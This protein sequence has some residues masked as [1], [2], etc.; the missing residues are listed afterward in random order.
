MPVPFFRGAA[1]TV[2]ER[3]TALSKGTVPFSSNENWDSPPLILSPVLSYVR[4]LLWGPGGD[5][6]THGPRES[7]S[8][9]DV[10]LKADPTFA[11][12]GT[13]MH[14][15][16]IATLTVGVFLLGWGIPAVAGDI[17]L[18][19]QICKEGRPS[20]EPITLVPAKTAVVVVD[21]WDRHW[22]KTYTL[23]VGNL[24]P[25]MNQ[26]LEAAR[27][28]GI[29]VVFAP[30][31]VVGFYKN[32]PQRKAMQAVP[33]QREPKKIAFNAPA[34]PQPIRLLRVRARPAV[35]ERKCLD[36]AA[37]GPEI[38]EGDL[39]GDCNNGRELLN[40]CAMRGID[41]LLYMGVASNMCVQYRSMGMRNMKQHGLRVLMTADLVE[42]ITSNGLDAARKKDLNFTPAGGTARVQQHVEQYLAPTFES[43]QLL[44]AAGMG[45]TPSTSGRTSFLI[46]AESEY[47]SHK[48]L[49]AFARKYLDKDYHCTC[50]AANGHEGSGRDDIPGLEAVDD[51]DLVVLSMRRRSLPVVQ[52]DHLERYLAPASRWWPCARASRRFKP[53]KIPSRATWCGS[54]STRRSWAAI[55]GLQPQVACHRLRRMGRR[56]GGQPPDPQRRGGEISQPL[57]AL[58]PASPGR[59]DHHAV[60]GSLVAGR[61]RR[62]RGLDEHLSGRAGVLHDPGPSGRFSDRVVQSAVGE[63]RPLGDRERVAGEP[64]G[65][66]AEPDY[67]ARNRR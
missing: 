35:Q 21:M 61:S 37:R 16:H 50:L 45:C 13:V 7:Q 58:P 18:A 41:T 38:A 9:G 64:G 59:H 27:K 3:G 12:E 51:A 29:Q 11:A 63:C 57:L 60:E 66:R 2:A 47:E 22:C 54:G 62:T 17:Q 25:R 26:T 48:T 20:R 30:S 44:A 24:V 36:A 65:M 6:K 34:P 28:L 19:A 52:M 46:A 33:P 14:N 56:R 67:E 15:Y 43:R 49:P 4:L 23:R 42:A 32:Y 40:L 1:P 39:I 53:G 31:D 55:P 5:D 10:R 8:N